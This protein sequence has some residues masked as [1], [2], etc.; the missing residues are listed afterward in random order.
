VQPSL[1][2]LVWTLLA[3]IP[4]PSQEE[5]ATIRGRVASGQSGPFPGATIEATDT[6]S[7]EAYS[8]TSSETGEYTLSGLPAGAYTLAVTG[9]FAL[10]FEQEDIVLRAGETLDLDVTLIPA[11]LDTAG[12]NLAAFVALVG[13]IPPPPD[14]PT[15]RLWNGRPDLS[16]VWTALGAPP[17]EVAEPELLPWARERVAEWFANDFADVPSSRCLPTSPTLVESNLVTKIVHTADLLVTLLEGESAPGYRQVFLDGRGHPEELEPTWTGHSIGRWE[18]DTL[19]VETTGLND[20]TWLF[21]GLNFSASP[22]TEML[23]VVTRLRRP[24]L[25]H[26]EVQVSF[27]DPGAL[28]NP[29]VV[30]QGYVLAPDME[31]QEYICTENNQFEGGR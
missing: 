31:V 12:E 28:Q 24:D 8:T 19:V 3:F 27:E 25:G 23:R 7:E 15:P 14:G 1:I 22:H 5:G 6:G 30:S 17:G 9:I 11:S 2:A 18:G 26:L 4:A 20:R 16:G 21:A 29:W 13:G 10:P